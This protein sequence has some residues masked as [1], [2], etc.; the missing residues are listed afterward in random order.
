M[1]RAILGLFL[2]TSSSAMTGCNFFGS[3]AGAPPV[4]TSGPAQKRIE[5][6]EPVSHVRMDVRHGK[7]YVAAN[8]NGVAGEFIFDTGSPTILNHQF[9][10]KKL[11]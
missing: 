1:K 6:A 3:G 11:A 5:R 2:L 7:Y 10:Q 4:S 9:A 8:A